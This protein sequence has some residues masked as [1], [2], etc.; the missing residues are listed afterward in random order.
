[1]LSQHKLSS[2]PANAMIRLP[3]RQFGCIGSLKLFSQQCRGF[4]S[5]TA[6]KTILMSLIVCN[7]FTYVHYVKT[8]QT[9]NEQ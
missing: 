7:Y 9:S 5:G 3:S 4:G 6:Q 8:H 2:R 1:M